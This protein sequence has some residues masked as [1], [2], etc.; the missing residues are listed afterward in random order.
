MIETEAKDKAAT[1]KN[2]LLDKWKADTL[3]YKEALELK[4][5]LIRDSQDADAA[6]RSLIISALIALALYVFTGGKYG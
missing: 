6:A 2:E 3:T 1:R 4:D 5:I